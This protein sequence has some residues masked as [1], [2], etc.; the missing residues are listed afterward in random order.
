[1]SVA[2]LL[3][4]LIVSLLDNLFLLTEWVNGCQQFIAMYDSGCQISSNRVYVPAHR[5]TMRQINMIPHA[6]STPK[7][8]A[9]D[10]HDTPPSHF[11]LT[12]GQPALL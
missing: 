7:Y 6:V 2:V 5:S 8:H 3:G 9:A 10:K 11:K 12:P 4:T 1:V